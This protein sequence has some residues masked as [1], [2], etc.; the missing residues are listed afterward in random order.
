M[1]PRVEA[2][3]VASLSPEQGLR[4]SLIV[5]LYESFCDDAIVTPMKVVGPTLPGA[6][7]RNA[8]SF[9]RSETSAPGAG[10]RWLTTTERGRAQDKAREDWRTVRRNAQP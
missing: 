10:L 4:S 5:M 1:L 2:V 3:D 8:T 9:Q 7:E 6:E